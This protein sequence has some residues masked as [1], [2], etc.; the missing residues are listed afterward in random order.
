MNVIFQFFA[1]SSWFWP[2]VMS[3][4]ISAKFYRLKLH[5]RPSKTLLG[6]LASDIFWGFFWWLKC[7]FKALKVETGMLPM[8]VNA[9]IPLV[10]LYTF[11]TGK[12]QKSK[13]FEI[14]KSYTTRSNGY[15]MVKLLNFALNY[16][17]SFNQ[18]GEKIVG[19]KGVIT[20]G[21]KQFFILVL[22]FLLDS[23]DVMNLKLKLKDTHSHF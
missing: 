15:V 14:L 4:L 5:F 6:Y 7:N 2:P 23:D 8:R 1:F 21:L 13:H 22:A 16:I 17:C 11:D 10:K 18:F 9:Q 20:Q 3:R 19:W 12:E